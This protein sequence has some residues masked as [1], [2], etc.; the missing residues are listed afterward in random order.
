M[1]ISPSNLTYYKFI[2]KEANS[3]RY[4]VQ[5]LYA[6][7]H[8]VELCHNMCVLEDTTLFNLDPPINFNMTFEE[9]KN[10]IGAIEINENEVPL[11]KKPELKKL[12]RIMEKHH[13]IECDIEKYKEKIEKYEEK[14][15]IERKRIKSATEM[16]AIQNKKAIEVAAI[17]KKKDREKELSASIKGNEILKMSFYDGTLDREK[18]K[19]IIK[20][21]RE[22]RITY[23]YGFG[24]RNPTT[25]HAPKTKEEAYEI[26][27]NQGYLDIDFNETEIHLNAF[28]SNDMW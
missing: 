24:F 1:K 2:N 15:N 28:S 20:K 3:I 10:Y 25:N 14:A 9:Y 23:T 18:A 6:P 7:C 19:I 17:I 16:L 26:I 5:Y 27:D 13:L 12:F 11:Y 22:R 8:N 21:S 4:G